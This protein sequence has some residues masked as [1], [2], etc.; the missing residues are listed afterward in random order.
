MFLSKILSAVAIFASRSHAWAPSRLQSF[1]QISTQ[2]TTTNTLGL[3]TSLKLAIGPSEILLGTSEQL[4]CSNNY[5]YSSVLMSKVSFDD[6]KELSKSIF[7]VLLFGGGLIPAAISA[8]KAMFGTIAG[9][10]RGGD[11]DDDDGQPSATSLDPYRRKGIPKTPYITNSQAQGPPVPLS[12]L[13]FS[14]EDIPLVDVIAVVGRLP[15]LDAVADWKNLPSTTLPNVN[16]NNPPMWLPRATFKQNVRNAKFVGWPVDSKGQPVGGQALKD[17]EEARIR[18]KGAVFGDAALDAVFDT[19]AW[20]ASV[21]TPDKVASQFRDWRP[22][23]DTFEV[24]KFV[25][26]A[27]R[28]RSVTG[29]G[30]LSFIVIQTVAY[31]TLFIAPF[32][33]VFFDIDIGFGE[34]GSCGVEGCK[35]F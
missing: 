30:I 2:S 23:Q 22:N 33:R 12:S 20:G 21:A 10:R 26:A 8:N 27:V 1:N 24:L 13:L 7:I 14:K 29:L 3:Q 25:G 15:S 5:Y 28:G 35:T 19:W 9:T 4:S 18:Q 6:F 16:K 11:P 31:G 32:F 34:L 17:A